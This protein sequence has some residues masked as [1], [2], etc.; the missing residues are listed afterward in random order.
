MKKALMATLIPIIMAASLPSQ[1]AESATVNIKG[2]ILPTACSIAVTGSADYSVISAVEVSAAAESGYRLPTKEV[3]LTVRCS[4]EVPLAISFQADEIA[5]GITSSM[6]VP[7]TLSVTMSPENNHRTGVLGT[8]DGKAIGYYTLLPGI[9]NVSASP[10][11]SSDNGASW[12]RPVGTGIENF[13]ALDSSV[14]YSWGSAVNGPLNTA[15]ISA[16]LHVSSTLDPAVAGSVT[17]DFSFDTNT[18]VSLH[19]L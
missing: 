12:I 14:L 3:P 2:I 19:Y 1:A 6:A 16:V 13:A 4:S 15:N 7:G 5:S 11:Y 9:A 18:T 10:I 8:I 17:E